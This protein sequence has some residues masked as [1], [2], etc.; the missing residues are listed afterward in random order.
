[1]SRTRLLRYAAIV[2]GA[3]LLSS[4]AVVAAFV[5][6]PAADSALG[7]LILPLTAVM[8]A[9]VA[10]NNLVLVPRLLLRGRYAAYGLLMGVTAYLVPLAGFAIECAVRSRAGIP[11]RVADYLS[12]WIFADALSSA[13]LVAMLLAGLS[14]GILYGRWQ[15]SALRLRREEG[16]LTR[17]IRIIKERLGTGRIFAWLD[18][19]IVLAATDAPAANR[20]IL[21]LSAYLREQLYDSEFPSWNTPGAAAP[22]EESAAMADFLSSPRWRLGRHLLLQGALALIAFGAFFAAP[23]RPVFTL[24]NAAGV[25]LFWLVL[26]LLAYGNILFLFPRFMRRGRERR[27]FEAVGCAIALITVAVVAIQVMTY[28][29]AVYVRHIPMWIMALSTASSMLSLAL[30]LAGTAS[31]MAVQN[32]IRAEWR[33]VRLRAATARCEL[34]Y[35]RK[36]INPHFLFNVLNNAGVLVYA[37]P[38]FA[39]GM[40]RQ[41]RYLLEYQLADTEREYTGLQAEVSFLRSYMALEQSRKSRL[42]CRLAAPEDDVRIPTL[43]FIPFVENAVKYSA[44]PV[45]KGEVEVEFSLRG[46][47]LEFR[48]TN[49]YDPAASGATASGHR[50]IGVAN[51][52][53]RLELLYGRGFTLEQR[54]ERRRFVTCLTI[55]L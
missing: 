29:G 20:G 50:G 52:R 42:E 18:D 1:M 43:L 21:E 47:R 24:H 37:D 36:Q 11:Q 8:L 41:L 6:N 22:P 12:P 55:P 26:N 44:V 28:D 33:M 54:E 31:V 25:V 4:G 13:V 15:R 53:R 39:V 45:G 10:V 46:S 40:L 19:I 34:E 14:L 49:S 38:Q 51:T 27:Y 16:A 5:D 35:L 17:R 23:D 3:M 9:A 7:L 32:R 48:C 2:A 30:F